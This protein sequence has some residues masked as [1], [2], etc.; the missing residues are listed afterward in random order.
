MPFLQFNR[1]GYLVI[2]DFATDEEVDSMRAACHVLVDEM[3][4][5]EHH[6]IFSTTQ[7]VI[8]D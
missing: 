2:E 1:D 6:T 7:L 5:A 4:P 8:T 3:N